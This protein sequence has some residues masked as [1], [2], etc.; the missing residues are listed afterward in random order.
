M[1]FTMFYKRAMALFILPILFW[2]KFVIDAN[3]F[4]IRMTITHLARKNTFRLMSWLL[5]LVLH[6]WALRN[7]LDKCLRHVYISVVHL[8]HCL[9]LLFLVVDD[10]KNFAAW[11]FVLCIAKYHIRLCKKDLRNDFEFFYSPTCLCLGHV[12]FYYI[13]LLC[14]VLDDRKSF[15][16]YH[17]PFV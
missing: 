17:K 10:R 3:V 15:V 8:L 4:D 16:K 1:C 13:F 9:Y 7:C 2:H 12:I 11:Q 14:F 6:V 5:A